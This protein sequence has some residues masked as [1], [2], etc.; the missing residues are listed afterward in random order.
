MFPSEPAKFQAKTF[1]IFFF[2]CLFLEW[3]IL[4]YRNS[5]TVLDEEDF[6]SQNEISDKLPKAIIDKIVIG[7]VSCQRPR[8]STPQKIFLEIGIHEQALVMMRTILISAK[9]YGVKKVDFHLFVENPSDSVWFH[10]NMAK[11]GWVENAGVEVTMHFHNAMTVAPEK[12]RKH[13]IY[14]LQ[15][16]CGF[17]RM[18]FSVSVIKSENNLLMSYLEIMLVKCLI[19]LAIFTVRLTGSGLHY[20][21]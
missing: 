6:M 13:M 18:F 3:A 9:L 10:K 7:I 2:I 8:D 5:Y 15:Y 20:L 4:E 12:H 19:R 1:V 16:R 11:N 17:V 21:S 14:H